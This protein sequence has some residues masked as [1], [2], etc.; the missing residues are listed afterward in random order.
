[1][2][3][4]PK[5]PNSCFEANNCDLDPNHSLEQIDSSADLTFIDFDLGLLP[6]SEC[7]D[8]LGIPPS[9]PETSLSSDFSPFSPSDQACLSPNLATDLDCSSVTMFSPNSGGLNYDLKVKTSYMTMASPVSSLP[10]SSP[11]SPGSRQMARFS[12]TDSSKTTASTSSS[13]LNLKDDLSELADL[14]RIHGGGHQSVLKRAL[15]E[16]PKGA[17]EAKMIKTEP[18]EEFDSMLSMVIDQLDMDLLEHVRKEIK[19]Q[20]SMLNIHPGKNHHKKFTY[21]KPIVRLA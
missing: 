1:M 13:T 15:E 18:K 20:A 21:R 3:P 19:S 7:C 9:S 2:V 5:Q 12:S 6:T 14:Q 17:S 8:D 16:G 11:Y 10:P 4:E